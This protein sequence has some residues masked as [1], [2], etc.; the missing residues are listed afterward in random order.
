MGKA[1]RWLVATALV[2]AATVGHARD[3]AL[4]VS[5]Q[6]AFCELKPGK[7]ECQTETASRF[8]ATHFTLHGLWP[9]DN[10][11]CGVSKRDKQLDNA[12]DWQ[13]LPPVTLSPTTTEKLHQ[14]MPGVASYLDRHE[15]IRH[16][17]CSN[18]NP[19]T[20]FTAAMDLLDAVNA[21]K[22]QG[23]MSSNIGKSVQ[24]DTLVNAVVEDFGE[25]ARSGVQFLCSTI[26]KYQALVEIRFA[27]RV[28]NGLPMG[29]N[30]QT[31]VP[32]VRSA[33][34]QELCDRG[35]VYIDAVGR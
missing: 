17:S 5:W 33:S 23:V 21:S 16:G 30:S 22:L 10:E 8:D 34:E 11:W 18:A 14:R 31:L 35:V 19:D 2:A 4:S 13:R 29:V 27:L 9:Q 26:G 28:A 6:P 1:L 7:L 24:F 32:P 15:W 20:Y 3:F 12:K 25:P